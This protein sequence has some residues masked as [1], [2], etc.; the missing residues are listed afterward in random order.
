M[1][2]RNERKKVLMKIR[3]WATVNFAK[4]TACRGRGKAKICFHWRSVCSM[5]L[6]KAVSSA[7]S[8]GIMKTAQI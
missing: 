2:V 3:A 1:T 4:Y 8:N 5:L 7:I 6:S